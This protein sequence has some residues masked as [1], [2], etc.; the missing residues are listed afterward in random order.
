MASVESSNS[1]SNPSAVSEEAKVEEGKVEEHKSVSP[2][3]LEEVKN[4]EHHPVAE[5]QQEISAF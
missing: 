2:V 5:A 1:G 3:H 4:V